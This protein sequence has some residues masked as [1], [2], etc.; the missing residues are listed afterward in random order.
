MS[1]H[2][3]LKGIH[4]YVRSVFSPCPRWYIT[5][6]GERERTATSFPLAL[7]IYSCWNHIQRQL[8]FFNVDKGM[9]SIFVFGP[10]RRLELPW[11]HTLSVQQMC[12]FVRMWMGTDI[13]L[14]TA[15]QN[16]AP[17]VCYLPQV[18]DLEIQNVNCWKKV[19]HVAESKAEINPVW[20]WGVF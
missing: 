7:V 11:I 17:I 6:T 18:V 15:N 20:G 4:T 13:Y 19:T 5:V 1:K 10:T 12:S 3:H 16:S 14:N 2:E 8:Q 9:T